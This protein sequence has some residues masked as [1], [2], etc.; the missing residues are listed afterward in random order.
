M[1]QNRLHN[2]HTT[3]RVNAF[4]DAL[5]AAFPYTTTQ[6]LNP[7]IIT[8]KIA[9][10]SATALAGAFDNAKEYTHVHHAIGRTPSAQHGTLYFVPQGANLTRPNHY[11]NIRLTDMMVHA[12][13]V[14]DDNLELA[15][16]RV[17]DRAQQ[18]FAVGWFDWHEGVVYIRNGK[19]FI[20][21]PSC[22]SWN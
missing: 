22:I 7:R 19:T 5:T 8:K 13:A 15:L 16:R 1:R 9:S 6:G 21:D 17:Q 3:D 4:L 20:Y 12:D 11:I 14:Q 18:Y 2:A 10:L